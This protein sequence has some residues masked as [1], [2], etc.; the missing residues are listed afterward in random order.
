MCEC[1]SSSSGWCSQEHPRGPRPAARDQVAVQQVT[2][3]CL[4]CICL[5]SRCVPA[6]SP[7]GRA[8]SHSW[9]EG[10]NSPGS[11]QATKVTSWVSPLGCIALH[12]TAR[13]PGACCAV[14]TKMPESSVNPKLT[15][16]SQGSLSTQS[17]RVLG[18][19]DTTTMV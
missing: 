19:V 13:D 11:P 1:K 7:A 18:T 16:C 8:A 4:E 12:T 17:C 2:I 9:A 6:I 3:Q 15:P 5:G 10:C 14:P